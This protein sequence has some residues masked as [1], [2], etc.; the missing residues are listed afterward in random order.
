MCFRELDA[1]EP[2]KDSAQGKF[3]R[4]DNQFH[5]DRD[6]LEATVDVVANM[7]VL[8]V[9]MVFQVSR[10]IKRRE[11]HQ[12]FAEQGFNHGACASASIRHIYPTRRIA[13]GPVRTP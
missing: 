4:R 7:A 1:G 2:E 12:E 11:Y 5:A 8:A 9:A 13:V 3:E 10:Y 6:K